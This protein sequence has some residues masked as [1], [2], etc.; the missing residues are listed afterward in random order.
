[1]N[2]FHIFRSDILNNSHLSR[3]YLLYD[4]E[5]YFDNIKDHFTESLSNAYQ[6]IISKDLRDAVL[7]AC[8]L[9]LEGGLWIN[10][11]NESDDVDIIYTDNEI[12]GA[13]KTGH[14]VVKEYLNEF[15]HR[16]SINQSMTG[17]ASFVMFNFNMYDIPLTSKKIDSVSPFMTDIKPSEKTSIVKITKFAKNVTCYLKEDWYQAYVNLVAEYVDEKTVRINFHGKKEEEYGIPVEITHGE[18]KINCTL[19]DLVKNP[20]V[21]FEKIVELV[22][23]VYQQ[24]IPKIIYYYTP[25]SF[26][27]DVLI[28][29]DSFRLINPEYEF[30]MY[31]EFSARKFI[32]DNFDK[33]IL[34]AYDTYIPCAYKSDLW[35]L[36]ILYKN[37]GFYFDDK[38][39]A[40]RPLRDMISPED[41]IFICSDKNRVYLFNGVM[42]SVANHALFE[43]AIQEMKLIALNKTRVHFLIGPLV[44]GQTCAKF[45]NTEKWNPGKFI[46]D[47]IKYTVLL[48]PYS[49]GRVEYWYH[50]YNLFITDASNK[51]LITKYHG[52]YK[53]VRT[54]VGY[55][56]YHK[57]NKEYGT[58]WLFDIPF[59]YD[60]CFTY[61]QISCDTFDW[62]VKKDGN[63]LIIIVQ[64]IDQIS[65]WGQKLNLQNG[66]TN[67]YIGSSVT[68]VKICRFGPDNKKINEIT[69]ETQDK[70]YKYVT[71]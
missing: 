54:N 56:V 26:N 4:N 64:R 50:P 7:K 9:Y 46:I 36:C 62:R 8:I 71:I 49:S 69:I 52:N 12:I 16:H 47:N 68:P 37:G 17:I 40:I 57:K 41:N 10:V 3:S 35:R 15:V 58:L 51:R 14:Y 25:S 44:F 5:T 45:L 65:G 29:I 1:M 21:K 55:G 2:K 20:L 61:K 67:Y 59:N 11:E 63:D 33:D 30:Q 24:K 22:D 38:L 53:P 60:Y 13:K 48:H 66:E 23:L 28:S 70:L 43:N 34:E 39:F 42:G 27:K 6:A 18:E 32:E 31:N 19:K